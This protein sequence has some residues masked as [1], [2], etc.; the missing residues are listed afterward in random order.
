MFFSSCSALV[1]AFVFLFLSLRFRVLRFARDLLARTRGCAVGNECGALTLLYFVVKAPICLFVSCRCADNTVERAGLR[2]RARTAT[3]VS[4]PRASRR[5]AAKAAAG[6]GNTFELQMA[7]AMSLSEPAKTS[8]A[9]PPAK[10]RKSSGEP[11]AGCQNGSKHNSSSS[12]SRSS[13]SSSSSSSV[14][15]SP[16]TVH[17]SAVG[18]SS[19]APA[20]SQEAAANDNYVDPLPPTLLVID[21]ERPLKSLGESGLIPFG[22]KVL[23]MK[24]KQYEW[25]ADV[26]PD[27][28]ITHHGG[29]GTEYV[30]PSSFSLAMKRQVKADVV[31]DSG[32]ESLKYNGRKLSHVRDGVETLLRERKERRSR[33]ASGHVAG[34]GLSKAQQTAIFKGLDR[35]KEALV[36]EVITHYNVTKVEDN[37]AARLKRRQKQSK[38]NYEHLA[39]IMKKLKQKDR[40]AFFQDD[41][42]RRTNP[43]FESS[44]PHPYIDF[45]V[46]DQ[47]YRASKRVFSSPSSSPTGANSC[48]E[49]LYMALVLAG[50]GSGTGIAEIQYD[51]LLRDVTQI[52]ENARAFFPPS[53]DAGTAHFEAGWMLA[54]CKQVIS[55]FQKRVTQTLSAQRRKDL[56][57]MI[58]EKNRQPCVQGKWHKMPYSKRE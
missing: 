10:L 27:G 34:T 12:S 20:A 46:M 58:R 23:H 15:D 32:W 6:S 41:D 33:S 7:L 16:S 13:S 35:K 55:S 3:D 43:T 18:T 9:P 42:L 38:R 24:Y 54:Q 22:E 50:D 1:G 36:K 40:Y 30:N 49:G 31:S 48:D 25:W 19:S 11:A 29:D 44:I 17:F 57:E 14:A 45:K 4:M 39:K 5:A 56:L 26:R 53:D 8:D 2:F 47:R 21:R 51:R 28:T 37:A 52:A